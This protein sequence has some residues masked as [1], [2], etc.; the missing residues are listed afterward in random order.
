MRCASCGSELPP[1][2]HFCEE[3][4]RPRPAPVPPADRWNRRARRSAV[5]AAGGWTPATVKRH[6]RSGRATRRPRAGASDRAPAVLGAV[7]RPRRVHAAR[8][9]TGPRGDQRPALALLRARPGHHRPLR[10]HGREVHRRCRHGRLGSTGRERGRRRAGRAGR[11]R[12]RGVGGRARQASPASDLA[13]RA[14][15]VTGEVAITDR[16]GGR[17]HGARRHRQLGL[18]GAE[19]RPAGRGARRRVDLAG[20]LGRDRLQRGRAPFT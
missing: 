9:E 15:V 3:C 16:Q 2:G 19:R 6:R 4:G 12:G 10:R 8:R 20:R 18:E 1:G 7:R 17:G 13:A 5:S 14:G 11:P